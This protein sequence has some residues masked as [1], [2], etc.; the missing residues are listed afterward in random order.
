MGVW[1]ID[2]IIIDSR[3]KVRGHNAY[4]YYNKTYDVNIEQLDYGDY[5]FMTTDG[6]KIVFE[7]KTCRDFISSMENKS[8]FQELSNQ[9]INN[10]YSYLIVCGDFDKTLEDVYFEVSH[11]R[12]KYKTMQLLKLRMGSQVNGALHRIYAMYIPIIFADDEDDAFDK[13]LKVSSKVA[14]AKKYGGVVRPSTKYLNISPVEY[15]LTGIKGIGNAKA[16]KITEKLG[17]E[18]LD[19][20]CNLSPS[21]FQSVSNVKDEDIEE[22]WKKIHNE[23]ILM[24]E[25]GKNVL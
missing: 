21:D 17:L 12:Y 18:C 22:L 2:K 20:L 14:D 24:N 6:K 9:T 15:Y 3:E 7:F 11:Y 25:F 10:E 1:Y 5:Q 16:K 8:L 4:N 19:D 23:D 13:M